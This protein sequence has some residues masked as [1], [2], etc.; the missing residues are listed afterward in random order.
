[1]AALEGTVEIGASVQDGERF[2]RKE[3]AAGIFVSNCS[4]CCEMIATG[5]EQEV[6]AA[7]ASHVC[8]ISLAKS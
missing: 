4:I 6:T 3:I 1:M 7:E 5:L 8:P 2:H